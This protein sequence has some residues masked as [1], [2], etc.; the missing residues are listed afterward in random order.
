MHEGIELQWF[1]DRNAVSLK[2]SLNFTKVLME[3]M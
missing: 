2:D 3:K 1:A